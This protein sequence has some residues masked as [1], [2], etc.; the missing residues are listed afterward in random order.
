MAGIEVIFFY[1]WPEFK[2][3]KSYFWQKI[4]KAAPCTTYCRPEL[5]QEKSRPHPFGG[6]QIFSLLSPEIFS[7]ETPVGDHYLFLPA[8]LVGAVLVHDHR[9]DDR[10]E[11][12]EDRMVLCQVAL[13]CFST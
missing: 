1:F 12:P 10:D 4:F 7:P 2:W 8:D 13:E 6:N 3:V 11:E 9:E 5:Q